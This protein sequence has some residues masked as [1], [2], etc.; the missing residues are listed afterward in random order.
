MESFIR[1]CGA[2]EIELFLHIDSHKNKC[3]VIHDFSIKF[4]SGGL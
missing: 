1:D 3:H 4:M 2:R